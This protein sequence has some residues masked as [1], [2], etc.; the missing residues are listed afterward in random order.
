M[1]SIASKFS[2]SVAATAF[3]QGSYSASASRA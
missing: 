3:E 1:G 2:K